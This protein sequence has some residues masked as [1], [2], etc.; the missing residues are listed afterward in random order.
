MDRQNVVNLNVNPCKM[1]MPMG[2]SLAFQGIEKSMVLIHGSQGCSTYIRRHMAGHYN[3]PID[4]ASS[5]L[6]EEGTVYGGSKNLK[7]GIYNLIHLYQPKM[8]GI[9]SSCL[10][11]TI[12]DD[13]ARFVREIAIDDPTLE[14]DLI[15][16]KTPGY[17]GSQTEG[18]YSAIRSIA[19][20]YSEKRKPISKDKPFVNLI[21]SSATCE[22]IREIKNIMKQF[23]LDC[24]ILPDISDALD[25]P[26]NAH[27]E[28]LNPY[29]TKIEDLQQ[30]HGAVATI[31]MGILVDPKQ[32]PGNF[33]LEQCDIPLYRIPLPVG[34][35]FTDLFIDILCQVTGRSTPL[36][37]ANQ[38]GRLLDAMIDSHKYNAPGRAALFGDMELVYSL[39]QIC[40][41]N[42]IWPKVVATGTVSAR[43]RTYTKQLLEDTQEEA[44][45]L[46][47]T[48]MEVIRDLVSKSG[49]NILIGNGDG[50]MI[51]EQDGIDW[52]RVGFPIHDH[53]G[54]QRQR[55]FG[56][57][58]AMV[59]LDRITNT[60]LDQKHRPY[61]S[62]MYQ[63]YYQEEVA[64]P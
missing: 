30:L 17:G 20:Y 52:V 8:I 27:Y 13:I 61:R 16:V 59:L 1:C 50:K 43:F 64:R 3:E 19:A 29:G 32:S 34:L 21:V 53:V 2:A 42:G 5:S 60:L 49:V 46:E 22:D 9:L 62:Q 12:G 44:I 6:T 48:D 26:F 23:D 40:K 15:P 36:E 56:Y 24:I 37:L 31:E 51:W 25:A 10:A 47:D 11:E 55:V 63:V 54:A 28:K 33:L 7:A 18:Y 39:G 14:V 4:I 41:E 57:N 45:I 35:E 38:R 58:G